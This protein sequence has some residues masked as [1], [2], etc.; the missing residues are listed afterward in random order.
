MKTIMT[1]VAALAVAL[2]AFGSGPAEAEGGEAA[3]QQRAKLKA[4]WAKSRARQGG[5][6]RSLFDILFGD[7]EKTAEKP[8]KETTK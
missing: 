3:Q 4:E 8:A 6:E 2:L 1:S 5:E 7:E